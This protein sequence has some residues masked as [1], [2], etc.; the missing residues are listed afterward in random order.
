MDDDWTVV[1]R[2]LS[3]S[4]HYENTILI[5]NGKPELLT[6]TESEKAAGALDLL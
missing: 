3:L 1:S 5:T 6:L 4:A 2:D